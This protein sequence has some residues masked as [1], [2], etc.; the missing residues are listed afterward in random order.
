MFFFSPSLGCSMDII[1]N[2]LYVL[3]A[4]QSELSI[5]L[6]ERDALDLTGNIC[7]SPVPQMAPA[8]SQFQCRALLS[9][10]RN[11]IAPSELLLLT[12]RTI[13]ATNPAV[14]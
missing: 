2:P 5:L 13:C 12:H 11:L 7:G 3:L 9:L 14:P 8:G 6:K 10:L 1:E 4:E